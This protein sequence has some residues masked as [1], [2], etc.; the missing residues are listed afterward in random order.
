MKEITKLRLKE[1]WDECVKQDK[2]TEFIIS[3]MQDVCGAS[4]D[5]VMNFIRTVAEVKKSITPG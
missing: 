4:F 3:Y 2:S 1:V 5:C